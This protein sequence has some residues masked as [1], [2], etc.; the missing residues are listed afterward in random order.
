M[1]GL[2]QEFGRHDFAPAGNE[3]PDHLAVLLG[4]LAH[5]V[6]RGEVDTGASSLPK[7][8]CP[9]WRGWARQRR[10]AGRL[11]GSRS[12]T[13]PR[14]FVTRIARRSDML[15]N[16]IFVALPYTALALV[17][18]VTPYRYLTNRLTWS[19][20]SSQFLE[21]RL[22]YWGS[23]PWHYGMGMGIGTALRLRP[24]SG[25]SLSGVEAQTIGR[26]HPLIKRGAH[27]KRQVTA[28]LIR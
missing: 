1:I 8:S 17:L 21:R 2:K 10:R 9:G 5:L 25:R 20:Y 19:A 13:P 23:N 12:S 14:R 15:N 26:S 22:L 16:F 3:L 7:W 24:G 4:F 6:Q 18:F 28:A 11:P 27:Q